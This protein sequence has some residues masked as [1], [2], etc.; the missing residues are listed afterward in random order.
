MIIQ[1][2]LHLNI[3]IPLH[4]LGILP[5]HHVEYQIPHLPNANS[6]KTESGTLACLFE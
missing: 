2:H 5:N 6:Q 3:K 1:Q 4:N